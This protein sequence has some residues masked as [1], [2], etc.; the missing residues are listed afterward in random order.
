MVTKS[1]RNMTS[2]STLT[3]LSNKNNPIVEVRFRDMFPTSLSALDYD[4]SATDVDY[5]KANA[6]FEY[7]LYEII[8]L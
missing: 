7:Q 1:D 8:K 5:M 3:I 2:D 4:Q 6:T